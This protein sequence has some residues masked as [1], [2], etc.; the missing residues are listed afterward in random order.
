MKRPEFSA[1]DNPAFAAD[2]F[3]NALIHFAFT[4]AAKDQRMAVAAIMG[5]LEWVD[6]HSTFKRIRDA[7]R[8]GVLDLITRIADRLARE[9]FELFIKGEL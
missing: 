5:T 9:P 7:D 6:A 8:E 3:A 2:A 4:V 1:F